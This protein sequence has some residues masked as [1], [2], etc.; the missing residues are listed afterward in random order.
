MLNPTCRVLVG[1]NESGKTNVLK[2]L[3]LLDP[4]TKA[5]VDDIRDVGP[6]E[7]PE[8]PSSV[9]FIFATT[10]EERTA[11]Y[12]RVLSG[13]LGKSTKAI[14]K[15]NDAT[16]T[17]QQLVMG[18]SEWLYTVDVRTN[19]RAAA[20]LARP[21]AKII[22]GWHT[23]TKGASTAVDVAG[24]SRN[25]NE[26]LLIDPDEYLRFDPGY[27][28]PLLVPTLFSSIAET[29][30]TVLEMPGV[31]YWKY[32]EENLLPGSISLQSF[33]DDPDICIPL[34]HMFTLA[35]HTDPS[36]AIALAKKRTNGITNLLNAVARATTSHIAKVWKEFKGLSIELSPNGPNVEAAIKD[37]Y[38]KF[39]LSRRSDGF[40]RFITFLLSVSVKAKTKQLTNTLYLHDE[41][42][43]SLHPSGARY[44]R[45][46]LI[47]L[48]DTNYVVYST[49]SIFMI[50]RENL[51]RHLIV[52]KENETTTLHEVTASNIVD[53]EVIYNALGY[54]IFEQLKPKNIVFEGW[55]DKRLFQVRV[56]KLP[57][58][59]ED[60]DELKAVG[61]C[62]VKGVGDI[63]R[64]TPMLE[65]AGR[66]WMV[67][68][69][70]DTAARDQ[71]RKYHGAGPWLR[72]DELGAPSGFV[73]SEDF[74]DWSAFQSA[75][76]RVQ[77][78]NP[79]LPLVNDWSAMQ[80]S[81]KLEKI[82]RWLLGAGLNAE[83]VKPILEGIKETAF[84]ELKIT[85][86]LDE[87]LQVLK[88][89]GAKLR[90]FKTSPPE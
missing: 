11:V 65:L 14:V 20:Y 21:A 62:H 81:G 66:L 80:G 47:R 23:P 1:I 76:T 43:T 31:V 78:E 45:D 57:A 40:K 5:T 60:R 86:I 74:I 72:Y 84:Q 35:G 48:A 67:V 33:A 2:A 13:V 38:N 36:A 41:P 3:A 39:D 82:R 19:K 85:Q 64:V 87:Y 55:R 42:D 7:D 71:Q 15:E 90:S 53:E 77:S 28:T 58:N 27:R 10:A 22:S 59:L 88:A 12:E 50:D 79:S 9:L 26:F 52:K 51:N 54:S 34:Q 46:E 37:T 69:D 68:S 4:D 63:G 73:T 70:A 49:H 75:L 83:Q 56:S 16:L 18:W 25:L 61:V 6:D 8:E 89:I 24:Q 30:R 44:L 17:L 29:F 32:D